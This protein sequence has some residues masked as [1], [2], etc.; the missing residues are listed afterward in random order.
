LGR[1]QDGEVGEERG[2]IE[3]RHVQAYKTEVGTINN[4]LYSDFNATLQ[5]FQAAAAAGS[6]PTLSATQWTLLNATVAQNA[7]TVKKQVPEGY[8]KID[9][10]VFFPECINVFCLVNASS[11][12]VSFTISISCSFV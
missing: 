12:G 2:A 8:L 5:Q 1:V 9:F 11:Y 10:M 3:S 4:A 6:I 7:K